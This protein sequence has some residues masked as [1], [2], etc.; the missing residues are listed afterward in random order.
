MNSVT[1]MNSE[2]RNQVTNLNPQTFVIKYKVQR[3]HKKIFDTC[4][5]YLKQK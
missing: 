2:R 4:K 3:I 5:N 1:L